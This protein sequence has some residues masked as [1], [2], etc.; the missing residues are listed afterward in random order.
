MNEYK[1]LAVDKTGKKMGGTISA[2]NVEDFMQRMN[3]K[4]LFCLHYKEELAS[5]QTYRTIYPLKI[6][7]IIIF[8][9]QCST[10]LQAGINIVRMFEILSE[11]SEKERQ[12]M[13]YFN[14]YEQI[15]KGSTLS[16]AMRMQGKS[17]PVLLINM[18]EAGELS[19]SL[20]AIMVK[21]CQHYERENV[22]YNKVKSAMIYP[23]VLAS[24]SLLVIVGVFTFVL[25]SLFS[26]FQGADDLPVIT[27][28]VMGISNILVNYWYVVLLGILL[29]ILLFGFL[30]KMDSVKRSMDRMKLRL[31]IVGKLCKVLYTARFANAF[32]T[33]YSSGVAIIQAIETASNLIAN[34]FY[35]EKFVTIMEDVSRGKGFGDALQSSGLFDN[36]FLSLIFTG[37]EAGTLD[38]IMKST[39]EY[40]NEEAQVALGRIVSLIEPVMMVLLAIIIGGIVIAIIL[41]IYEMYASSQF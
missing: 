21:M 5:A 16:E 39:S 41:P 31:P 18:I 23:I 24:V 37:E 28:I 19:G 20:E 4:E 22:L 9:R 7:E 15:Q 27:Q 36:M 40:Y 3:E 11:R 13:L 33:L 17:F 34:T 6:K 26:M 29:L 32:F 14:V 38:N 8:C 1:Y 12:K 2:S 35:A 30:V 10:M 25:P